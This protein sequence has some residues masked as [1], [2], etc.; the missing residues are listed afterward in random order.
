VASLSQ[1]AEDRSAIST[2]SRLSRRRMAGKMD[3]IRDFDTECAWLLD[4]CLQRI[5]T[6]PP[7]LR[8]PAPGRIGYRWVLYPR[9]GARLGSDLAPNGAMDVTPT[10][11][12]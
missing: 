10:G 7:A 11:Q 9:R 5:A 6:Y 8:Q 1:T 2:R 4:A 3:A 12:S